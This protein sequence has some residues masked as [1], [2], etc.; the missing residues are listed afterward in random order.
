MMLSFN[1]FTQVVQLSCPLPDELLHQLKAFSW[2]RQIFKRWAVHH[3]LCNGFLM[4]LGAFT[5]K[6]WVLQTRVFQYLDFTV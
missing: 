6:W 2:G 1:I 4:L 3:L 5:D